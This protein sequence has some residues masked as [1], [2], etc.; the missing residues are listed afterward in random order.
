MAHRWVERAD[1]TH[2]PYKGAVITDVLGG[3]VP[4]TMQNAAAILPIVRDGKL[5]ERRD[6]SSVVSDQPSVMPEWRDY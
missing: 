6:E 3:R 2:V 1:I 5:R 4:M